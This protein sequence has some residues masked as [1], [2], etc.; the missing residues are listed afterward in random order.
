MTMTTHFVPGLQDFIDYCWDFYGPQGIYPAEGLTKKMVRD[1]CKVIAGHDNYCDG[2]SG[3]RENVRDF[4]R[5]KY[6]I[7]FP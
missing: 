1:A 6:D 5:D 3:D 7:E 4:I 2:D